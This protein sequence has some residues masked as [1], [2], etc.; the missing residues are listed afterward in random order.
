MRVPF[1]GASYD[2]HRVFILA[3]SS[4]DTGMDDATYVSHWLDH[5]NFRKHPHCSICVRV[6]GPSYQRD[7]L[8][9]ALTTM[10]LG[11]TKPT[12]AE[13]RDMW[14]R[15]A[16]GNFILREMTERIKDRPGE[17][18]WGEAALAFH[19]DLESL[20]PRVCLVL[21]NP[22]GDLLLHAGPVLK[23]KG[24]KAVRLSH[25]TMQPAPKTEVRRKAWQ[26]CVGLTANTSQA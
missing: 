5:P 17:P 4:W 7:P 2:E 25:L 13:R 21:D 6:G 26:E 20:K 19:A 1:V 12:D 15:I 16:F 3:E 10:M 18:E 22:K 8:N 9:D 23:A 14:S 11:R 24:V